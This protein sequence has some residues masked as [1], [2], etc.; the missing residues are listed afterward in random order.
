MIAVSKDNGKTFSEPTAFETEEDHGYCYCAIHFLD[1]AILL[2][3]NGEGLKMEA[4]WQEPG[5]EEYHAAS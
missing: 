1:D 3:Y 2:G 5:L 4:A